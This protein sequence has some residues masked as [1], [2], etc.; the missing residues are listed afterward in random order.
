[1]TLRP[2]HQ[3]PARLDELP[4]ESSPRPMCGYACV[5]PRLPRDPGFPAG[6]RQLRVRQGSRPFL[7]AE[8]CHGLLV[9]PRRRSVKRRE[10]CGEVP[11]MPGLGHDAHPGKVGGPAG[12]PGED[13]DDVVDVALRVGAPG[14]ARRTRSMAAGVSVSSGCRPNI[15]VPISQARI[16]P[17]SYSAQA[18]AWPG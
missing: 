6:R 11:E 7:V 10:P 17:S 16:P 13:L 5:G 3:Y 8:R 9:P 18:G 4:L 1:M 14:M 2:D 15:T 12:R